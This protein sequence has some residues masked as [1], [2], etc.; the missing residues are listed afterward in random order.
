VPTRE[1]GEG[2][3]GGWTGREEREARQ[4]VEAKTGQRAEGQKG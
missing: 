2:R 3:T 1:T 4:R